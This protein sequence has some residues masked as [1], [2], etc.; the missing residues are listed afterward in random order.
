MPTNINLKTIKK[1][2]KYI[3][4]LDNSPFFLLIFRFFSYPITLLFLRLNISANA[5]T[6]LNFLLCIAMMFFFIQSTFLFY[7]IAIISLLCIYVLDC[8]DGSISRIKKTS[9]FYG[10]FLDSLFD[11]IDKSF[12]MFGL[13]IF[14]NIALN[15]EILFYFGIISTCISPFGHFVLDKYS[16]LARWQ[17]VNSKNKIKPYI[18]KTKYKRIILFVKDTQFFSIFF[19]PFFLNTDHIEIFLYYF[20]ISH[21]LLNIYTIVLHIRESSIRMNIFASDRTH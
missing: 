17:N 10:R 9:T 16:A 5:T 8:V 4:T 13:S 20:F 6:Y 7:N 1:I 12:L 21:T 11:I 15:N 19:S 3:N 14:C 2:D 18:L